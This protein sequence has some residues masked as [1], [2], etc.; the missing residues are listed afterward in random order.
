MGVVLTFKSP[1]WA[2][3]L[4][5]LLSNRTVY[6]II[7]ESRR[8]IFLL[9]HILFSELPW[10][11]QIYLFYFMR[12]KN[13]HKIQ[14]FTFRET[15]LPTKSVHF[16]AR[17]HCLR[18]HRLSHDRRRGNTTGSEFRLYR[19]AAV[20]N[21][22]RPQ[23]NAAY[24]WNKTLFLRLDGAARK[25]Y[26]K[27]FVKQPVYPDSVRCQVFFFLSTAAQYLCNIHFFLQRRQ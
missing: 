17:W 21:A 26:I 20:V 9:A 15:R 19:G 2:F 10:E 22:V 4:L 7:T 6:L 18:T 16:D 1:V 27:K 25:K 8:S 3:S 11:I 13:P 24:I 14:S 12:K 5:L 23:F